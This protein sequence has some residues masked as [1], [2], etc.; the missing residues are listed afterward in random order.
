MGFII[1]NCTDFSD[2]HALRSLYCSLIRCICEYGSIIWSPYQI[3]YKLKL[4]NIQQKCLRFL[5]YKC[6]IPRYPHFSYSPQPALL[7]ILNL[8]TLERRRLRLDLYF[9]YKLFSG[10]IID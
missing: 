5:S 4:E 1:R 7:S 8:E 6:S 9:A 2:K 3:S 10:I